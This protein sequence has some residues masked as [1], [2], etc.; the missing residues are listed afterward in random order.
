MLWTPSIDYS[1][2]NLTVSVFPEVIALWKSLTED[3]LVFGTFQIPVV[4]WI[5]AVG[6]LV[7]F[8]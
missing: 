4:T 1:F 5:G 2:H 8:V 6:L 3:V 7:L